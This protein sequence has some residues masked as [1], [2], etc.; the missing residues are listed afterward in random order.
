LPAGRDQAGASGQAVTEDDL[1]FE[2][3]R[4][5]QEMRAELKLYALAIALW[6]ILG[7]LLYLGG[8]A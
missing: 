4:I 1:F 6:G 2:R 7:A 3:E 8:I 5:R